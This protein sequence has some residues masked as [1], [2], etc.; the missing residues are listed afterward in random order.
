M[1]TEIV[2]AFDTVRLAIPV[3]TPPGPELDDSR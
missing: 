2:R 1:A 3:S